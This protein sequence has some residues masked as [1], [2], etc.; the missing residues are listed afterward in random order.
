MGKDVEILLT[1]LS[2]LGGIAVVVTLF[3]GFYAL[4]SDWK[5]NWHRASR[6]VGAGLLVVILGAICVFVAKGKFLVEKTDLIHLREIANGAYER[7]DCTSTVQLMDWA[8]P[9]QP[10]EESLYRVRARANKR[11]GN[12]RRDIEDRMEVL[13]LNPTRERN[14]L[15][16][17]E[18]YIFLREYQ[19]AEG[20]IDKY[21]DKLTDPD[22]KE[23][24]EFF[25]VVCEI[26]KGENASSRLTTFRNRVSTQ[27]LSKRFAENFWEWDALIG[28]AERSAEP[29][30]TAILQLIDL[31]IRTSGAQVKLQAWE[32]Q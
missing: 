22:V 14:H 23:M 11:L 19:S 29:S 4:L 31:L 21:R 17:I 28:F 9:F 26:L 7:H 27:P 16:I 13:R 12:H 2:I 1:P 10:G 8:I 25:A 32:C 6:G 30:K 3:R 20:W 5:P 18:D 24:F 15:P